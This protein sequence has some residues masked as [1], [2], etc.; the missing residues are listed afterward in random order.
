MTGNNQHFFYPCQRFVEGI[1]LTISRAYSM[2][3]SILDSDSDSHSLHT[4]GAGSWI[5]QNEK[6]ECFAVSELHQKTP[7]GT[8][9][10]LEADKCEIKEYRYILPGWRSG[11]PCKCSG[12]TIPFDHFVV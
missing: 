3:L 5:Y 6:R 11:I 4:F 9:L 8:T 1:R 2:R 7:K 12:L 10:P